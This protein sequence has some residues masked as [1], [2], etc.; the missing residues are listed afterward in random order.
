MDLKVILRKFAFRALHFM[1]PTAFAL[2]I[3]VK[4]TVTLEFF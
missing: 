4:A 1:C 2:N 3:S